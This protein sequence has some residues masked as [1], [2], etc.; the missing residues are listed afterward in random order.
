MYSMPPMMCCSFYGM[1]FTKYDFNKALELVKDAV[2][3]EREDELLYDYLISKAPNNE[4]KEIIGSIRDD[5][6]KHRK[7][8]KFVYK[9]YTGKDIEA[10][11]GAGDFEKPRSY[12]DGIKKLCSVS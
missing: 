10:S 5:E 11:D 6:R 4:E 2:Q 12:I 9:F 1:D 3:G 7:M 8:F